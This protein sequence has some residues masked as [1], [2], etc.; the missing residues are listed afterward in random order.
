MATK[1]LSNLLSP[2]VAA[3][4]LSATLALGSCSGGGS[5][6]QVKGH[7]EGATDTTA[8]IL[9]G[10]NQGYWYTIDTIRPSKNGDFKYSHEPQGYPDIYR[11]RVGEGSVYFPID[12][13]E[14]VTVEAALPDIARN[15]SIGGTD[16]AETLAQVD[17]LLEDA[18]GRLGLK[19]ML[20][21]GDVKRQLGQL[22][23][24]DPSGIVAYYIVS[25]SV[26]GRPLFN[27]SMKLDHRYI[28][29]V[30]NAFNEKRRND[31]RT[32]YLTNL[33]MANRQRST[34]N[35]VEAKVIGAFD[36]N[37]FD[38][39]GVEHSLLD[40][41]GQGKVVL[42]NFTTYGADWS[43]AFNVELNRI[44]D[45]YKD[46]GFEIYQVSMDTNDYAWK[47]AARNLP[48]VTVLN[49]L[50]TG[51]ETLRNYNVS[52]VPTTF[53]INRDGEIVERVLSVDDLDRA[54]SAHL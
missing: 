9:E 54:V 16:Q 13:I 52:V 41:A 11:L 35:S 30:A 44:Y 12:S 45:K 5:K 22:I 48:W 50:A 17:S 20:T 43:P 47:Q 40:I 33:F 10:H 23:L 3:L 19:A 28:G 29:A 49:N 6:W 42:L 8:V 39:E 26:E 24:K 38:P 27:P 31:P 7:I 14:T 1:Y 32:K 4:A 21:D 53:V 2:A 18:R 51:S 37:L 15:H 46:R 34:L 36:I 25:K